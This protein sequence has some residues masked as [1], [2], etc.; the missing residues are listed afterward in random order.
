MGVVLPLSWI[1]SILICEVCQPCLQALR[2]GAASD[3]GRPAADQGRSALLLLARS[4]RAGI[5]A[6]S[7][8]RG[9]GVSADVEEFVEFDPHSPPNSLESLKAPC[10]PER[11]LALTHLS[12]VVFLSPSTATTPLHDLKV[13]V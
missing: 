3:R 11:S 2:T 12:F 7:L 10:L 6:L 4:N 8:Q 13:S 9:E 1:G 5:T